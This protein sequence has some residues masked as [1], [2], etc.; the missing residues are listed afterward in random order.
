LGSR[1]PELKVPGTGSV[2]PFVESVIATL[3]YDTDAS[4]RLCPGGQEML[5]G[6]GLR[7][8]EAVTWPFLPELNVPVA[9]T[10]PLTVVLF[11]ALGLPPPLLT[12][13]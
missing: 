11:D 10:G 2:T 1:H 7:V 6:G 3:V 9:L 5:D 8:S 4:S 12:Q 13:T